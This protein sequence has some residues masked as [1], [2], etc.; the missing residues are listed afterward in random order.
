MTYVGTHAATVIVPPVL[1]DAAWGVYRLWSTIVL[2]L[3]HLTPGKMVFEETIEFNE[4]NVSHSKAQLVDRNGAKV[5]ATSMGFSMQDRIE[6]VRLSEAG[7]GTLGASRITDWLSPPFFETKFGYMWL[8]TFAF[9]PWH[10]TVYTGRDI[11]LELCGHLNFDL[12]A[13]A[14]AIGIPCGMPYIT[15]MF[16]PRAFGDRPR[17]VPK[18]S[19]NF[20]FVSQF[21]EIPED[22]VSTVEYSVRAAQMAVCKLLGVER[23]VPPILH[24]DRSIKVKLDALIKA[25]K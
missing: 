6:L 10:S 12:N 14:S 1:L 4:R 22:V 19:K 5:D 9:Q 23:E 11:L 21:V 13:V 2:G 25:F 16:T 18:S 8:T 20:A 24:H 3:T 15:S 17:P 7:E